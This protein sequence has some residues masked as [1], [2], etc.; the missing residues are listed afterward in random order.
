MLKRYFFE[1]P[2]L[3]V[4]KSLLKKQWFATVM[5]VKLLLKT[6]VDS[7]KFAKSIIKTPKMGRGTTNES[8]GCKNIRA[9]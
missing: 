8:R 9:F 7:W 4:A 5:F 1:F 3:L 2:C 6:V